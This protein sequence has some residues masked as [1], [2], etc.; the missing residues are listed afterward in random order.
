M[1]NICCIGHKKGPT[2]FHLYYPNSMYEYISQC[3]D[4]KMR[5]RK[6]TVSGL[7]GDHAQNSISG[8]Y[9]CNIRTTSEEYQDFL[10]TMLAVQYQENNGAAL[11]QYQVGIRKIS[12]LLGNRAHR[13][14]QPWWGATLAQQTCFWGGQSRAGRAVGWT[15]TIGID[16]QCSLANSVHFGV[17]DRFQWRVQGSSA[18]LIF[19]DQSDS[20]NTENLWRLTW[21]GPLWHQAHWAVAS[22]AGVCVSWGWLMKIVLV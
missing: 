4:M 6:L 9:Q 14:G 16:W 20:S 8:K 18:K 3:I 7:L 13:Q 1:W 12:G 11:G 15:R 10:V 21:P 22:M 17:L 5:G 2:C 19:K